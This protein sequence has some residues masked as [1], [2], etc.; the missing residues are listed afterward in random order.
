MNL[1]LCMSYPVPSHVNILLHITL[2]PLKRPMFLQAKA[3]YNVNTQTWVSQFTI[4]IL[5]S[6]RT[7]N[8]T[9]SNFIT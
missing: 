6:S 4:R 7:I 8:I 5:E 2:N 1:L 3:R 9:G